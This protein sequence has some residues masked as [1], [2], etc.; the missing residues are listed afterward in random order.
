M[1][2]RIKIGTALILGFAVALVATLGVAATS[3]YGL[4]AVERGV[5]DLSDRALPHEAALAKVDR[6]MADTM[7]SVN[8]LFVSRLSFEVVEERVEPH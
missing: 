1:L 4:H 2:A 5:G 6:A 3:L 8:A 7:R